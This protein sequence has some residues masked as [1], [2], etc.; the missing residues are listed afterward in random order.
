MTQSIQEM[1]TKHPV[2]VD[3]ASPLSEAARLMRDKD[4]GDVIVLQDGQICGIVTDR[5]IVVRA[6]ADGKDPSTVPAGDI[7]SR[8]MSYLSPTD[9]VS[10]A[11]RIMR[12]KAIRRLPIVENDRPVGVV[13]LGDLALERDPDSALGD[14]SG[15]PPNV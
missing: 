10:D 15:A 14:I 3:G 5:D 12:E 9:T 11:V 2:T 1:M 4:V 8:D 7:C 6:V 13:S